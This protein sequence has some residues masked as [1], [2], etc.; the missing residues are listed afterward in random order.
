[1]IIYLFVAC[2]PYGKNTGRKE[3]KI[4]V[5]LQWYNMSHSSIIVAE[6]EE[7]KRVHKSDGTHDNIIIPIR[8]RP[9]AA[10]YLSL[11]GWEARPSRGHG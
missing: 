7:K 3:G 4:A 11:P 9:A 10:V 6:E 2:G 1:M 8:A 5:V